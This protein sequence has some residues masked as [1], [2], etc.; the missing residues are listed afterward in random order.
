LTDLGSASW[1]N[2]AI[3]MLN[4][5]SSHTKGQQKPGAVFHLAKT[6]NQVTLGTVTSEYNLK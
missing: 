1:S 2:S 6:A 4:I 5:T 3:G